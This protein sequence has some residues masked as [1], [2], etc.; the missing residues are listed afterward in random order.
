MSLWQHVTPAGTIT[1]ADLNRWYRVFHKARREARLQ[2]SLTFECSVLQNTQ[3]FISLI[4]WAVL[5]FWHSCYTSNVPSDLCNFS[6]TANCTQ[7]HYCH[8]FV[9]TECHHSQL[10]Q[11]EDVQYC[12]W[13]WLMGH[14]VYYSIHTVVIWRLR[15]HNVNYHD[16]LKPFHV[17]EHFNCCISRYTA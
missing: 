17:K 6:L 16:E 14:P 9:F 10:W 7:Q 3:S 2:P 13:L 4:P 12:L 1:Q 11:G 5:Q 15:V 8:M